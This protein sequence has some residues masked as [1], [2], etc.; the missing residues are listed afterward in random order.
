MS[1]KQTAPG[2]VAATTEATSE[3]TGSPS[4]MIVPDSAAGRAGERMRRARLWVEANP[5]AVSYMKSEAQRYAESG[6]RFG[7]QELAEWVR[8]S[9]FTDCHGMPTKINNTI[10]PPL[11]RI[12]IEQH[13]ECRPYIELRT[14]AY[15]GLCGEV[16]R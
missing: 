9:D 2:A 12:L 16:A 5:G 14:R 13:P 15:D 6:R 8:R 11:A 7:M 1:R 3:E 10:V 4:Q